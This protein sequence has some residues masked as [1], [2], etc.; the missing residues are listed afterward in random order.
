MQVHLKVGCIC[1]NGEESACVFH[2]LQPSTLRFSSYTSWETWSG[3]HFT[4]SAFVNDHF[5]WSNRVQNYYMA[6][7]ICNQLFLL[8]IYILN[9]ILDQILV[10][11]IKYWSRSIWLLKIIIIIET[12]NCSFFVCNK[13]RSRLIVCKAFL[14][15]AGGLTVSTWGLILILLMWSVSPHRVLPRGPDSQFTEGGSHYLIMLLILEHGGKRCLES[16]GPR[17]KYWSGTHSARRIPSG[18]PGVILIL[19]WAQRNNLQHI[20]SATS[21]VSYQRQA[22]NVNDSIWNS[23]FVFTVI[24]GIFFPFREE[25]IN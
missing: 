5:R 18:D 17:S 24:R 9:Q 6:H 21:K 12:E 2:S 23:N 15:G 14:S 25:Q 19:E 13:T 20:H 10:H 22:S 3:R 4:A 16:L 1:N 8:D 7:I 11:V